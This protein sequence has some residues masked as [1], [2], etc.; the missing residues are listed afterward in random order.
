V[1]K[2]VAPRPGLRA[3]HEPQ[4]RADRSPQSRPNRRLTGIAAAAG[5]AL[6]LASPALEASARGGGAVVPPGPGGVASAP[7]VKGSAALSG[8]AIARLAVAQLGRGA[9]SANTLGGR[10]FGASA[11]LP[12]AWCAAFAGWA[13]QA[14][15]GPPGAHPVSTAGL[16]GWAGS[17]LTYGRRHGTFHASGP[18]VGDAML[19]AFSKPVAQASA[20]GTLADPHR[21]AHV[22]IVVAVD[23]TTVTVANGDWGD[24]RGGAR[25]VRLSRFPLSDADAGDWAPAMEQYIAGYVDPAALQ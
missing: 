17:F 6:A 4:H 20:A 13:W 5:I 11:A 14:G 18:R 25:L 10:G 22:A 16:D 3:Q 2:H 9:F 12:G 19:S 7:A 1:G 24:G 21:I 23:A 15:G 8:D